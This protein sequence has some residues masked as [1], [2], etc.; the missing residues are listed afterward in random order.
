[1]MEQRT[2]NDTMGC[3]TAASSSAW[4]RGGLCGSGSRVRAKVDTKIAPTPIYFEVS[5]VHEE[6]SVDQRDLD[7]IYEQVQTL[8]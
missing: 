1:M 7:A 6:K 4:L 5:N 3:R 8:R 2:T